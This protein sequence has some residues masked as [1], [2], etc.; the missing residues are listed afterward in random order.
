MFVSSVR[1]TVPNKVHLMEKYKISGPETVTCSHTGSGAG[2][3]QKS[4]RE[5]QRRGQ[6]PEEDARHA[7]GRGETAPRPAGRGENNTEAAGRP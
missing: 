2:L 7:V 1:F 5:H 6:G 3:V 4:E